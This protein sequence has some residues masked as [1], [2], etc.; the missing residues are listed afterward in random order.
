MIAMI[1]LEAPRRGTLRTSL[2]DAF[3]TAFT[4]AKRDYRI[5]NT[6][7]I[8]AEAEFAARGRTL[9]E[10]LASHYFPKPAR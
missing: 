10:R 5:C 6:A 3:N 1:D 2:V 8:E 7:T 4:Q 9:A